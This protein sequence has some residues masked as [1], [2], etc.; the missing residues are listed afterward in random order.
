M[1][2]VSAPQAGIEH[3]NAVAKLHC[4][5]S[6]AQQTTAARLLHTPRASAC[7]RRSFQSRRLSPSCYGGT[8]V[9]DADRAQDARLILTAP[10]PALAECLIPPSAAL[11]YEAHLR[12]SDAGASAASWDLAAA[13]PRVRARD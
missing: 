1:V 12:G 6:A 9:T 10:E 5:C 13:P 4:P 11:A 2:S 7:K 8:S 3:Q